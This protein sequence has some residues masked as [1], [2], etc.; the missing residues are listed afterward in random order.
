MPTVL[1]IQGFKFSFYSNDHAPAHIH[2]RNQSGKAK[3]LL[4]PDVE[5]LS[6]KKM[7]MSEVH[8]AF[9]LVQEHRIFLTEAFHEF[10]RNRS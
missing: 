2:V 6:S 9:D 3:F 4:E 1:N 10:E 7:K 5:L 8:R